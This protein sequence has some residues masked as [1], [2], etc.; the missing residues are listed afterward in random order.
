M[1][2]IDLFRESAAAARRCCT[3]ATT[4]AERSHY[5]RLA[6]E[7]TRRQRLAEAAGRPALLFRLKRFG[8]FEIGVVGG[9]TVTVHT[10]LHG[11]TLAWMAIA[12]RHAP[13][14]TPASLLGDETEFAD[15][16][17]RKAV[18]SVF[19][20]WLRR[21]KQD[22]LADAVAGAVRVVNGLVV[23]EP[24]PLAPEIIAT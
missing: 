23:Y 22:A 5:Q 3:T 15:D 16:S 4:Q 7:L 21:I 6:A 18:K 12:H 1:D 2:D 19:V 17:A 24:G 13:H 20:N 9:A 8:T 14:M 11:A 10:T